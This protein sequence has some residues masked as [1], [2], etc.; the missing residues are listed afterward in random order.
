MFDVGRDMRGFHD[1]LVRS[2]RRIMVFEGF[3]ADPFLRE[4]FHRGAETVMKESPFLA[5]EVI[6]ERD[7]LGVI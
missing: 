4:K 3:R 6:Q 1:S 5:I 7:R 2:F